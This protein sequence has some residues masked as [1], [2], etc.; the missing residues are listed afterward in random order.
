MDYFG[1]QVQVKRSSA[2]AHIRLCIDRHICPT[3]NSYQLT[4]AAD[5]GLIHVVAADS[6]G[7]LYGVYTLIQLLKLHSEVTRDGTGTTLTVP[8]VS[9]SDRP[10]VAQRAVLWSYRCVC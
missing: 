4:V 1:F 3:A 2:G 9:I 5:S 10:D 6:A 8:P 7:L